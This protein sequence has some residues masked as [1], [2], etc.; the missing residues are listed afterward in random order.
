MIPSTLSLIW[1]TF[2]SYHKLVMVRA[3][4]APSGI[5]W[6]SQEAINIQ[7]Q[8]YVSCLRQLIASEL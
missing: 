6:K 3:F 8:R 4:K 5:S 1:E 2:L 7:D